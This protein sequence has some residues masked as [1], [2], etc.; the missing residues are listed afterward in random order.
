MAETLEDALL[1]LETKIGNTAKGIDALATAVRKLR[2]EAKVGRINEI[3]KVLPLVQRRAEDVAVAVRDLADGWS[4]DATGY[5]ANGQ[6]LKELAAIAKMTGLDLFE[7]D[8]RIYC[9]PLLLRIEPK[10]SGVRIGRK[11][12]RR[13]R[14]SE[15]TRLLA[16]AQQRPQRFTESQFLDLLYKTYRR[17]V[18]SDWRQMKNVN[19][20]AVALAD[21][22]DTLTLLP[23]SDYPIEEF[24]RDLL[25]LDRKPD[26]RTRDGSHF[27]LPK[28]TSG[29]E[30]KV[31]RIVVYDEKGSERLYI[32]IRFVKEG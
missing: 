4:F 32:R 1:G 28:S 18:G 11:I 19:G 12:E 7:R 3:E 27:H 24:A 16:A 23:G 17:I 8:G 15:L 31:R 9:F 2:A 29:K 30:K 26:L 21:L 20:P 13:I 22:Y 10:E 5:L 25:L 14:P 6:Y